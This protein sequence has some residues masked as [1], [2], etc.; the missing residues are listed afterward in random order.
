MGR[1]Y[2]FLDT[3]GDGTGTKDAA[4]NGS[5]TAV[6]YKYQPPNGVIAVIARMLVHYGDTLAPSADDY[7]NITA[8]TNGLLVQVRNVVDDSVVT[9]LL[10]G[11]PIKKNSDW[12]RFCYDLGLDDFGAGDNFLKVRWTFSKSGQPLEIHDAQYLCAVIQDDLTGLVEH[13]FMIQGK[14]K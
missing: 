9:D 3:V 6:T 10:D 1:I 14:T 5:S 4:V 13:H 8:L 2:R 7:G 11:E 12:S